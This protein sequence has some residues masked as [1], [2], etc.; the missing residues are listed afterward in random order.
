MSPLELARTLG[1]ILDG[2]GIDWVLGGS[3]AS[4]FLG[5]PRSTMDIDL[6]VRMTTADIASLV[7]AVEDR[8][9]V[10]ETMVRDAVTASSSF[11]LIDSESPY[12]VDIFVLGDG[13]LDRRQLSRRRSVT[14]E[15]DGDS[16]EIWIGSTEDQILR[17][18]T[19]FD[20]GGQVSDRQWRDIVG[21]LVAQTGH[22][23]EVDLRAT[24]VR[25]DLEDLLQRALEDSYRQMR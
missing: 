6:A 7:R 9:Y 13:E 21:M 17:K 11:N 15:L 10:S 4:S 19:W 20:E 18:L 16:I 24:A 3:L 8:F 2:I 14:I 1:R 25:L 5:E 22:F 23:D 12:K